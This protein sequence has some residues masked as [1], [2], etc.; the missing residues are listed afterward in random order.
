MS[1]PP[2][3]SVCIPIFNP[4]EYLGDAIASVLAQSYPDFEL[5]LV[6]DCSNQPIEAEIKGFCDH[7]IHFE[8]NQR[9]LGIPGNWNRC[10]ELARGEFVVIFHQDDYMRPSNLILK[11]AQ[12]DKHPEVGFI[13]SNIRRI[14][15][16]GRMIGWHYLPQ[17]KN[18]LILPGWKIFE[19]IS[20]YGNPIACQTVMVRKECYEHLGNFN[21]ALKYA[22]DQE[23][24]MRLASQYSVAFLAEPLVDLRVHSGQETRRFLN[25]GRDYLD[26]L[27]SYN[28]TYNSNLPATH[29][30]FRRNTY[31]TL[32]K[33]SLRMA[34]W[35]LRQGELKPLLQ[36]LLVAGKA[37]LRAV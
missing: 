14:D 29:A 20:K 13:Y 34:R 1:K 30:H 7:R 23:M 9:T 35:E 26:V 8:R 4:G 15:N 31:L 27:N 24:W 6:D 10:L 2:K 21:G 33:Q 3:I 5:I 12:L 22:T 37:M 28:I 25:S 11:S 32:T 17:P 36:Y 19:M 16:M 18:D